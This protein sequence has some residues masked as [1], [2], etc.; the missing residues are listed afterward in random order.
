M[1][2]TDFFSNINT[3]YYEPFGEEYNMDKV[4]WDTECP[5]NEINLAAFPVNNIFENLMNDNEEVISR[6][7][8]IDSIE[9]A[10]SPS[11]S[12]V[13]KTATKS[14]FT[15]K[16]SNSQ[17]NFSFTNE[18]EISYE[19]VHQK[20]NSDETDSFNG[21]FMTADCANMDLNEC[22]DKIL[23][24]SPIDYLKDQG[25]T[26]DEK[27]IKLLSVNKR[28]RKTKNQ[29][30]QLEKEYVLNPKWSKSFMT[31]LS[32]KL[33]LSFSSVYKWHWDQRNNSNGKS[34]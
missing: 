15:R 8:S 5:T 26:V 11:E 7:D 28:K 12:S 24:A 30:E 31:T 29:I 32:Q 18:E 1:S 34:K 14:E 16:S 33:N 4:W 20:M 6:R 22:V 17:L 3:H 10:K 23:N 27:T 25:I 13:G 21:E 2:N 19:D 9:K